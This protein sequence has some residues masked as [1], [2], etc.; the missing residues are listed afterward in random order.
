MFSAPIR[1]I[2]AVIKDTSRVD[3][4]FGY[5]YPS[6]YRA[7]MTGLAVQ[8][9]Y[10]T[11][12]ARDDISCERYFRFQTRSPAL[13]IETGRPLRDNHIIGF[14]LTYEEDILNIVQMLEVGGIPL[15]ASERTEEDPIVI[16][17]G[18]VVSANPEPYRD[19][20]DAFAIGEGDLIIHQI[21]NRVKEATSRDD[22]ILALA[23]IHGVYVPST[24]PKS[25]GRNIISSLDSLEYPLAQIIPDVSIGSKLEPVFGK[26]F[27]LEVTRGCGHSCRF[28]LVGHICQP[29]RT[30]SL[31]KLQEIIQIG[32]K[33]TP[34]RKV[35]LI[36]SSLGDLDRLEELVCW[37][38]RQG[39]E[40]SVPSLR[41]DSVT[42]N[43]LECLVEGGQR[44]LTIAPETG[45]T[46][47]RKKIGKGLT[48]VDIEQAI[49]IANT[50]GYSSLKLYFI[51]GL[52]GET[53]TD[54]EDTINMVRDI[55][56]KTTMKVIAS[57][58]PFIP[59][60]QTRWQLEPQA[61]ITELREKIRRI[62]TGL[63]NVPRV[64][65]ETLDVRGARI[66][67]ALSIGDRSL[68]EVIRLAASYGGYGGW[69]RAE[70]QTGIQVLSLAN[71]P[72]RFSKGIPWSYL[73]V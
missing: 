15:R 53:E 17:G 26:S 7:G 72:D 64:S 35:S 50:A 49:K 71:N 67:A 60:A 25:V 28:C 61:D 40:V 8:I 29:R 10:S 37:I 46:D 65:L 47:L 18:P 11:L 12:N 62:E 30:R 73:E 57:I 68:G 13:S 34:V 33:R 19:F 27:L 22:A 5:C 55:A 51:V 38:V 6:T 2:N 14:T 36:G 32:L 59:K 43:L 66:Q 52:P 42:K 58:N 3:L 24:N 69:R 39:L 48:D 44:T 20:V 56:Q 63:K 4:L 9:L 31:E 54:I 1:E 45:S 70:K 41:A 16:I 21:V 23:E